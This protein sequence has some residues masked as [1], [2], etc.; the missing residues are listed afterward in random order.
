MSVTVTGNGGIIEVKSLGTISVEGGP[1]IDVI[2]KSYSTNVTDSVSSIE[3]INS[4]NTEIIDKNNKIEIVKCA[5]FT[6]PVL[7]GFDTFSEALNTLGVGKLFYLNPTNLEGAT[8]YSVH[9]TH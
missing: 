7:A 8:P 5:T 2:N 4:N 1:R 3:I 9:L 6:M